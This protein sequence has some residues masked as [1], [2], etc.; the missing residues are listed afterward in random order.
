MKGISNSD[1]FPLHR[2]FVAFA[3]CVLLSSCGSASRTA[4]LWTDRPEFA[5]YAE[6]FNSSQDQY[7][8]E[9]RYFESPA[10]KLTD[11]REFPDI[12]AGSWLKSASTRSLF[13][14]LDYL[15]KNQSLNGASFYPRLLSLGRIDDKQ[16]LLPV[17]FN[18][19]ALVFARTNSALPSNLFTISLEEIKNLGKAYNVETNGVYTR[20][21]FPPPGMMHSSL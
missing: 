17:S 10:Q 16:Y 20:M 14:P 18:I 21:G 15:I 6:Y 2:A 11:T 9:A 1:F 5:V 19:P 13:R 4:V 3:A 7:K 8:I 12:V